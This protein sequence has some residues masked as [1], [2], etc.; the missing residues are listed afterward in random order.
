MDRK[1]IGEML[2]EKRRD[3]RVTPQ[4]MANRMSCNRTTIARMESGTSKILRSKVAIVAQAYGIEPVSL[5]T[6]L[7]Y[8]GWTSTQFPIHTSEAEIKATVQDLEYLITVARGL[9]TPM[10][11]TM[12]RDLIKCRQPKLPA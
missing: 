11:I 5:A 3:L 8:E 2:R 4:N 6:Q 10:N 7:G 9:Q 12:I 1:E